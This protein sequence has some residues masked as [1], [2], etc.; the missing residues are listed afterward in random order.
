LE[1]EILKGT[2]RQDLFYRINVV[3]FEL[4]PLRE[5]TVDIPDLVAYF[6]GTFATAYAREAKPIS[7]NLTKL[8]VHHPWPGNIREL[9]NL[10]KRYVILASEDAIAS[11]LLHKDLDDRVLADGSKSLTALTKEAVRELERRIILDVLYANNWNRKKAA[12]ILKI[13]YRALFY[14]MKEA[15]VSKRRTDPQTPVP[16]DYSRGEGA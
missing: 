3:T 14:K 2:F 5:R 15:G 4:P 7:S 10:M 6:V 13:S 16:A 8:L 9:E 12:S 1:D 11:E